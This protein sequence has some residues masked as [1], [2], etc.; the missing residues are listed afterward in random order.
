M[1]VISCPIINLLYL[2]GKGPDVNYS[3]CATGD[4]RLTG[5]SNE[6]EGRVEIC[7]NG[8]WG[9]ICD[10]GWDSTDASIVCKQLQYQ[11][12]VTILVKLC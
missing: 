9:S 11:G 8:V 4:L 12:I 1:Y 7:M 6:Y 3:A 5:G 10:Y 2:Y